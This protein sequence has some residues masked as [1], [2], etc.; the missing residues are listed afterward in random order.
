[1]DRLFERRP[2]CILAILFYLLNVIDLSVSST[3]AMSEFNSTVNDFVYY[4]RVF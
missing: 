4:D 3:L 2:H 1:M